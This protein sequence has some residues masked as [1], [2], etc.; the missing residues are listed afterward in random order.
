MHVIHVN[1][2]SLVSHRRL[3]QLCCSAESQMGLYWLCSVLNRWHNATM[4]GSHLEFELLTMWFY[5]ST[6]RNHGWVIYKNE[7]EAFKLEQWISLMCVMSEMVKI[8]KHHSWSQPI[9]LQHDYCI[10]KAWYMAV[11]ANPIKWNLQYLP[12]VSSPTKTCLSW[13]RTS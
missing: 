7:T 6:R 5:K 3:L 2:T 9:T 8:S 1:S 4:L 13:S 12:A 11:V 10:C